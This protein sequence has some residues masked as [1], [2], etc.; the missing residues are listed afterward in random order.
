MV[1]KDALKVRLDF[2]NGLFLWQIVDVLFGWLGV[3]GGP[4]QAFLDECD[5]SDGE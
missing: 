4:A 2:D 3:V 5:W 1:Y